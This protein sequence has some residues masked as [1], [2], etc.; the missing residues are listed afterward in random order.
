M[1]LYQ[2]K[3]FA[4][5]AEEGN[6]TRASKRLNASQP[7]VSAHIKALEDEL[8]LSLFLR[9]P[10]GM[11]LTVDGQKMKDYADRAL[12]AVG[13]MATAAGK[14][15]GVLQGELRIGINA[16][17]DMLRLAELFTRVRELHQGLQIHLLQTM[18]GEVAARLESGL[19]D[20]GFMYGVHELEKLHLVELRMARLVVVGPADLRGELE[21]ASASDLANFPWIMTP[22]DCPFH[23]VGAEFFKKHGLV[24]TQVALVDQ[25]PLIK[26]MIR[27]GTGLS[28]LQEEDVAE[29][30][31]AGQLA[32]WRGEELAIRLSIGCLKRRKDEPMLQALFSILSR[33]WEPES[34][35]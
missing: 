12:A 19:L 23:S 26:S 3:T 1:E 2:L 29:E 14:L 25:E 20:A 7:A 5:V 21:V 13:E 31:A 16:D 35:D 17:P 8:G 27:A 33:L 6:L 28:L 11:D 24:P 22:T 30:V 34:I 9:T 10:K 4:M 32:V 18:T 15:R